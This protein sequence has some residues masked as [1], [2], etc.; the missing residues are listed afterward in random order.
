MASNDLRP[1]ATS[2]LSTSTST[3]DTRNT[4]FGL[5]PLRVIGVAA[6]HTLKNGTF[7]LLAIGTIASATGESMPP[8]ITATFS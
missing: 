4:K 1:Y 5:A 6:A 3:A 8:N 2:A 7:S